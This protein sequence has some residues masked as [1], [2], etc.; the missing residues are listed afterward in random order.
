[1]WGIYGTCI[2]MTWMEIKK[3]KGCVVAFVFLFMSLRSTFSYFTHFFKFSLDG[4]MD[5]KGEIFWQRRRGIKGV[6]VSSKLSRMDWRNETGRTTADSGRGKGG[7][8]KNS[9]EVKIHILEEWGSLTRWWAGVSECCWDSEKESC[10]LELRNIICVNLRLWD[11][12]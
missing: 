10:K 7:P 4:W 2:I 11:S 5:W 6:I 3:G 9:W 8:P 12:K 1:M